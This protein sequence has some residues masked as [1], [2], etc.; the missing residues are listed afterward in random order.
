MTTHSTSDAARLAAFLTGLLLLTAVPVALAADA[1]RPPAQATEL[2]SGAG[3]LQ[4]RADAATLELYALESELAGTRRALATLAARRAVVTQERAAARKR[5]ELVKRAL[6][7]SEARL[8]ELVRAHYEQPNRAD[9]LAIVLGATS[10]EAALTGLDELGRAARE[11]VWVVE[12]ARAAR[13]RAEA[14]DARLEARASELA[15]LA[16][17]AEARAEQLAAAAAER[18]RFV[19]ALR[20]QHDLDAS[21][22]ASIEGR[23]RAANARTVALAAPAPVASAAEPSTPAPATSEPTLAGAARTLT[24]SSTGY[25]IRGRTATGI[26]TA[27]GVVAVDPAV[28]P[29]GTRLVIPGYGEGVAADTGGAVRGNA[30]DLWFPTL[31]Q[32]LAWGR[33]TVTITVG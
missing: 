29:L 3:P 1:S 25:A 4:A 10:F 9:A 15:R 26:P 2:G 33:R 23:A 20:R 27:P 17:S 13:L 8:G 16:A 7:V 32:A 31:E 22:V 24:V 12:R 21:R 14:L 11:S 6:H 5:L 28:I 18:Q 19:A 30:I